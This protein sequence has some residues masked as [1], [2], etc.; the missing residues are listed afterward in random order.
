M[1][2][3]GC[4]CDSHTRLGNFLLFRLIMEQGSRT[5]KTIFIG[6]ISDDVDE[7]NIYDNFSTF[8]DIIEVQLPPASTDPNRQA[9]W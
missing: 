2:V 3:S 6:G 5:K 4:G 8:G 9:G 7:T 1:V